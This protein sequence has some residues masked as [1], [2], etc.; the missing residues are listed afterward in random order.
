MTL[1]K[2]KNIISY[3]K[4]GDNN[5]SFLGTLGRT[6][7]K[8]IGKAVGTTA[9]TLTTALT[10]T[11]GIPFLPAL[12]DYLGKEVN[13]VTVDLFDKM[14]KTDAQNIE[15]DIQSNKYFYKD[16][17]TQF[18]AG[19]YGYDLDIP[20]DKL[21]PSEITKIKRV[22]SPAFKYY[23]YKVKFLGKRTDDSVYTFI[24]F[25]GSSRKPMLDSRRNPIVYVIPV[26]I[27]NTIK[28]EEGALIAILNLLKTYNLEFNF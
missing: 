24:L 23:G 16:N 6:V 14:F 12:S 27:F 5:S 3:L 4:E 10:R 19:D 8:S 22:I 2:I 28:D 17:Y 18:Q 21:T 25:K 1:S 11:S 26:N 7:G 13:K 9:G 20:K 15:K